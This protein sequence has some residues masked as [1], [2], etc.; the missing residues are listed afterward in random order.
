MMEKKKRVPLPKPLERDEEEKLL[1]ALCEGKNAK[2]REKLIL[3]NLRLVSYIVGR[4]PVREA[5]KEDLLQVGAIGLIKA[6]DSFDGSRMKGLSNYA[7]RCIENEI[8]MYLRKWKRWN[9]ELLLEDPG[10]REEWAF[11]PGK[12]G[13][14]RLGEEGS[15]RQGEEKRETDDEA[16]PEV[17]A[18]L[19]SASPLSEREKE[20]LLLRFCPDREQ[21]GASP[22]F[23]TQEETARRMG[24][25]QSYVSRL[26]RR[27]LARLCAWCK[28]SSLL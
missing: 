27:A 16:A 26:E 11:R 5:E 13:L 14:F 21:K 24:L 15:F 7:A 19:L 18:A 17:L 10:L 2:A 4:Y 23:L 25:S 12:E 20:V 22:V 28:K 6:V 9:R 3:H 8:R 1:R